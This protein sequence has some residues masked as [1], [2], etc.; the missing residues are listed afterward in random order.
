MNNPIKNLELIL[1][2]WEASVVFYL[3][4]IILGV[5][6]FVVFFFIAKLAKFISFSFYNKTIKKRTDLAHII[7]SSIY[8]FF[9]ISG[10]F[11][12]LQVVGLEKI[13]THILASAGIIGIIAGF[14]FKDI[15]SNIFSGLL[16][17][18][19]NPYKK[20]DWVEINDNYGFILDV[21]W[22]TTV[23]KT[24]SGQEVFIPNQLI[25]S[26]T[27]KN[28]SSFHKRRIV[29]S[30]GVSYGDDLEH[31]K[32]VALD[33]IKKVDKIL[34]NEDIDFYFTEIGGSSYNFELRFWIKFQKNID[35][36]EAMSESIIRI[37]KRFEQENI[38]I[39]YPVTTLDFGVK[40]GV[41]VFDKTIKVSS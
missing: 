30:T 27:F 25:Y 14:A 16:L 26:N 39:A 12:A 36:K 24:V 11:L 1:K 32:A 15:A 35:Y 31:V 28:Y 4:N 20:N 7:S 9:L 40:G 21:G 23:I 18:I 17:K 13:L 38:S 5:V 34:P 19:Q 6:I 2:H 10:V 33:E 41:N 29:L 8:F 3:P 22:I 37:K